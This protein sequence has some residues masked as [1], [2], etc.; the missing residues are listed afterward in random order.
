MAS[1]RVQLFTNGWPL[2]M[3]DTPPAEH[4][5]P[6]PAGLVTIFVRPGSPDTPENR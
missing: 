3:G 2:R 5:K 1:R 4:E 6:P